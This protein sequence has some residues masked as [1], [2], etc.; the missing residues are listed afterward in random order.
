MHPGAP[1]AHHFS[2]LFPLTSTA[3]PGVGVSLPRT[4]AHWCTHARA[5]NTLPRRTSSCARMHPGAP[6]PARAYSPRRSRVC[7]GYTHPTYP[8]LPT[9]TNNYIH[10]LTCINTQPNGSS[11]A[12]ITTYVILYSHGKEIVQATKVPTG[13]TQ[14]PRLSPPPP[15]QTSRLARLH[16]RR[17]TA[18]SS[19][20]LRKLLLFCSTMRAT[21]TT[22]LTTSAPQCPTFETVR[23]SRL[24]SKATT[25]VAPLRTC[26]HSWIPR[27]STTWTVSESNH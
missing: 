3:S 14:C 21:C 1:V 8:R 26:K 11:C 5:R 19:R 25:S 16:S 9:R 17:G 22:S 13:G 15:A 7:H 4:G 27:A 12:I 10:A 23:V 18:W 6:L 24:H 2:R 20:S